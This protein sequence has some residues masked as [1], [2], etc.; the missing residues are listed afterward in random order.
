ME[1]RNVWEMLHKNLL[2]NDQEARCD[3]YTVVDQAEAMLPGCFRA[4]YVDQK[5]ELTAAH[6]K[7]GYTVLA[8]FLQKQGTLIEKY[9]LDKLIANT[10]ADKGAKIDKTKDSEDEEELS[11][12][13]ARV[14]KIEA[15]KAVR[16]QD[17][18][19]LKKQASESSAGTC[20]I[21][22]TYHY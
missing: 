11:K 9:M 4:K 19:T 6:G 2:T 20:P 16:S 5:E 3:D 17:G 12:L 22:L 18:T 15:K 7:S 21:C 8:S 14:A 10:K 1:L 13:K